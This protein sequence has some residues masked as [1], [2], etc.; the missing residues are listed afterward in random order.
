[1]KSR[2]PLVISAVLAV[3]LASAATP[4]GTWKGKIVMNMA[5]MPGM[6]ANVSP[7]QK[8]AMMKQL[9]TQL[10]Q[11]HITLSFKADHTYTAQISG[12]PMAAANKTSTGKWSQT[13][14]TVTTMSNDPRTKG[15]SQAIMLSSDGKTMTAAAP[16]GLGKV[17]FTR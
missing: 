9:S 6:P 4:V 3:S 14:N 15:R 2:L 12:S 5:S 1:M 16:N 10:A 17:V 7:Q 11:M 8:A 13:G